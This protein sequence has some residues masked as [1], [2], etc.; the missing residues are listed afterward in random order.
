AARREPTAPIATPLPAAPTAEPTA[1]TAPPTPPVALPDRTS[2]A[3]VRTP[4]ATWSQKTGAPPGRL[5]A[6]APA[7]S[8]R[9]PNKTL[10]D[11]RCA[12]IIQRVSLGEPLSAAD[13]SILQRECE[14]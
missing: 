3:R 8:P 7:A 13:K 11:A 5:A 9:V 10:L 12:D 4:Q 1:D 14:P 2:Q 6:H